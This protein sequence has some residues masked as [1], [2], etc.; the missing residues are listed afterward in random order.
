MKIALPPSDSEQS[1]IARAIWQIK[2]E[3]TT[4]LSAVQRQ[5]DLLHEYRTRLTSDVVTGKLDVCKAALN[6][7]VE[8]ELGTSGEELVEQ[9]EL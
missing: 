8:E 5:I 2:T 9:E 3:F 6:L 1:Q 4:M 7:P